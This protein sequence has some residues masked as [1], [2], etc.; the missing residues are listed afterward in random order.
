MRFF[1]LILFGLV[2]FSVQHSFADD[3]DDYIAKKN[4]LDAD[5]CKN[6]LAEHPDLTEC[7]VSHAYNS[8]DIDEDIYTPCISSPGSMYMDHNCLKAPYFDDLSIQ[9]SQSDKELIFLQSSKDSD[10]KKIHSP[11]GYD[12]SKPQQ[13]FYSFMADCADRFSDG[14]TKDS[15]D[16]C[17]RL[18]MYFTRT[19]VT[20]DKNGNKSLRYREIASPKAL[21]AYDLYLSLGS[22]NSPKQDAARDSLVEILLAETQSYIEQKQNHR[23]QEQ[24]EKA[25]R[26]KEN[27]NQSLPMLAE[28]CRL[29]ESINFL[30][31]SIVENTIVLNRIKKTLGLEEAPIPTTD[32]T[33]V[34]AEIDCA[35]VAKDYA[36]LAQKDTAP[37][38]EESDSL[39][40]YSA[41]AK[42]KRF[43]PTGTHSQVVG[44]E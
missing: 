12:L 30:S 37:A 19:F 7:W 22:V 21:A 9:Y 15:I 14:V 8:H 39:R 11:Y 31:K 42:S 29:R 26:A 1:L 17:S 18:Q 43:S 38:V 5:S 35:K 24:E 25:A 40:S 23:K 36:A 6:A 3:Y 13:F 10:T 16:H 20:Y 33:N 27:Y 2:L 32:T 44:K 28:E 34:G 4:Q 41:Y